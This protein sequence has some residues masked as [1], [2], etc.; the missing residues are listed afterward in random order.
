M[1]KKYVM[2]IY[3][4]ETLFLLHICFL[5]SYSL[6]MMI[7]FSIHLFIQEIIIQHLI[8][9][10]FGL[11]IELKSVILGLI[12]YQLVTVLLA[13]PCKGRPPLHSVLSSKFPGWF[14]SPQPAPKARRAL[15][16]CRHWLQNTRGI[17]QVTLLWLGSVMW[18]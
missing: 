15:G 6:L 7:C 5:L 18:N 9:T 8:H 14:T 16:P 11:T 13:F 3:S 12:S 17:F 10:S 2:F 1:F 4:D